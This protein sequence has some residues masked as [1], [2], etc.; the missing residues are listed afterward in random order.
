MKSANFWNNSDITYIDI[1][2]FRNLWK[3]CPLLHGTFYYNAIFYINSATAT[4]P[5]RTIWIKFIS[6]KFLILYSY[7]YLHG[8]PVSHNS[9]CIPVVNISSTITGKIIFLS[10]I[11]HISFEILALPF[12]YPIGTN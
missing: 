6:K 4:L 2:G 7:S 11:S 10:L 9:D 1:E 12:E 8:F 3:C 5:K